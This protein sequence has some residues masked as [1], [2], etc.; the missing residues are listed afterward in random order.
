MHL[1][2]SSLTGKVFSGNR[3]TPLW[4]PAIRIGARCFLL[5]STFHGLIFEFFPVVHFA[6][7][8]KF[9]SVLVAFSSIFRIDYEKATENAE[10][11]IHKLLV[12]SRLEKQ[13][14]GLGIPCFTF[15]CSNHTL[16]TLFQHT[17]GENRGT[18]C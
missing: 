5:S 3:Q 16:S 11:N 4:I 8:G 6:D 1:E 9:L 14:K 10:I 18:H 12:T 17:S 2:N 13:V 15:F 7:K